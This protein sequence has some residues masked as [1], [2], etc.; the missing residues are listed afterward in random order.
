VRTIGFIVGIVIAVAGCGGAGKGK[1]AQSKAGGPG[2][3]AVMPE[4]CERYRGCAEEKV[5]QELR[6]DDQDHDAPVPADRLA[7][8]VKQEIERC[9]GIV[10]G[11]SGERMAWLESCTGC[12]GSCDV[13]RCLDSVPEKVTEPYQCG[14][15]PPPEDPEGAEGAEDE[16]RD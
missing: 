5:S 6:G 11:L 8:G 14:F 13:Y 10:R 2:A 9:G 16:D 4:Y 12:G 1:A 7:D 15:E 3:G